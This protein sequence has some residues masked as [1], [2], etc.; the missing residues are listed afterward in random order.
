MARRRL[1]PLVVLLPLL[2]AAASV[3]RAGDEI[4]VDLW[5]RQLAE[6]IGP[7][8]D[9]EASRE[10]P[11]LGFYPHLG[12]AAGAPS[13]LSLQLGAYLSYSNGRSFSLYGGYSVEEGVRADARIIT[14]GWGGVRPLQSAAPQLGFHG[15]FLRYRRW[16]HD[17]H[18]VHHG[19]SVGHESGLGSAAVSVEVGAARSDRNHWLVTLQVCLKLAAPVHIPLGKETRPP[20][21]K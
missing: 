16:D 4:D 18:G 7:E 19:L 21:E 2:A 10:V 12:V 8:S 17:D 1:R 14:L 5:H 9:S 3:S 20:G 13:W 6:A 11:G 15:K